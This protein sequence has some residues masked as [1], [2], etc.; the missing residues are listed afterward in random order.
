MRNIEINTKKLLSFDNNQK[1]WNIYPIMSK[2][3]IDKIRSGYNEAAESYQHLVDQD[4][5][6]TPVYQQFKTMVLNKYKIVELGCGDGLPIGKD[7]LD[8]GYNYH[9]IDLSDSQIELARDKIPEYKENFRQGEML[10]FCKDTKN[11]SLGGLVS[12]FAIFHLPRIH[13]AEL[14]AEILRILKPGAP[15]LFTCHPE[16]WEG[17]QTDWLSASEMYWSHFSYSWYDKTLRELGFEFVSSYRTVTEF[18]EK[19]EIRYFVLFR[20]PIM[21]SF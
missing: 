7:L 20:K 11:N 13:H 10:S 16:G 3:I 15:I 8:S 2:D 21:K 1:G 18:N 9:G 6:S 17:T 4:R 14:F 5:P 12:M 19:D